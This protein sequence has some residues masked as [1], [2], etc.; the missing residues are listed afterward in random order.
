[1]IELLMPKVL[2]I[3]CII[4]VLESKPKKS[5]DFIQRVYTAEDGKYFS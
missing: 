1:M 5:L 4:L 3:Y 2:N